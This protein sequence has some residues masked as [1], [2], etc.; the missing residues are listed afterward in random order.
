[1]V[2]VR[3]PAHI[4]LMAMLILSGRK[5]PA[6]RWFKYAGNWQPTSREAI[7]YRFQRWWLAR[8]S[9]RG[10]VTV[11]GVWPE[12]PAWIRTF[13]NP[14]LDDDDIA[15]GQ[16]RSGLRRRLS[17]PIRLPVRGPCRNRRRARERAIEV[18][19]RLRQRR[20]DAYLELL[21]DGDERQRLASGWQSS[22][23][24][25]LTAPGS[26]AGSRVPR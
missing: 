2:H 16:S 15:R 6:A 22:W 19:A 5:S 7:S 24:T 18:L 1:M 11:N 21:G 17:S 9:H 23:R 12:Q 25:S 13:F 26:W 8:G 14:S 4:A 20:I 10:V 3:G